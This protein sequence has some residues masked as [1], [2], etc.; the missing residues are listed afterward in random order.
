MA[1]ASVA[2]NSSAGQVNKN[3][4][5]IPQSGNR[6]FGQSLA[7]DINSLQSVKELKGAKVVRQGINFIGKNTARLL[8]GAGFVGVGAAGLVYFL[9]NLKIIAGLFAAPALLSFGLA[10]FINRSVKQNQNDDL[11]SS[12]PIDVLRK[13]RADSTILESDGEISRVMQAMD[14]IRD[15]DNTDKKKIEALDLIFTLA[16]PIKDKMFQE[17][18][19]YVTTDKEAKMRDY[20]QFLDLAEEIRSEYESDVG[21][22]SAQEKSETQEEKLHKPE[23]SARRVA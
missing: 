15:L 5:N 19:N 14:N 22:I 7:R 18:N 20:Q 10:H 2:Q 3:E 23:P 16:E 17:Q 8:K 12:D 9:T 11:A 21:S 13:A 6:K 1:A 4:I